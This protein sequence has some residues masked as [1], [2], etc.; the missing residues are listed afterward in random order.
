VPF[1]DVG[2]DGVARATVRDEH[3]LARMVRERVEAERQA[4]DDE[5][6]RAAGRHATAR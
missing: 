3:D 6:E 2:D 5:P 4:L 1:R